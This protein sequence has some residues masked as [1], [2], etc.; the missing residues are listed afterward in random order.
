[1]RRTDKV[2]IAVPRLI[3]TTENKTVLAG[4]RRSAAPAFAV[5]TLEAFLSAAFAPLP[6]GAP[7]GTP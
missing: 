5:F 1:M 2:P 6:A 3:L 7:A 4:K